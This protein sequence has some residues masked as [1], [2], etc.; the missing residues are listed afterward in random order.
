MKHDVGRCDGAQALTA[1]TLT[2]EGGGQAELS[3]Q[4]LERA[5]QRAPTDDRQMRRHR[6]LRSPPKCQIYAF[7]AHQPGGDDGQLRASRAAQ[8]AAS[9]CSCLVG[10]L[11]RGRDEDG[12]G[13]HS[14]TTGD[15]RGLRWIEMVEQHAL[16]G[17]GNEAEVDISAE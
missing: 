9:G 13:L 8:S 3:G 4:L 1:G 5:S 2:D 15:G 12:A 17:L 6:H 10:L 7:V 16:E 11:N 14:A